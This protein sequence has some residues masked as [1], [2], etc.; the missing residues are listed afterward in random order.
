MVTRHEHAGYVVGDRVTYRHHR[1]AG[2]CHE[3]IVN[4]WH[5]GTLVE[6]VVVANSNDPIEV[7]ST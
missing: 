5:G 3:L 1:T 2:G 4:V 6:Q 7:R